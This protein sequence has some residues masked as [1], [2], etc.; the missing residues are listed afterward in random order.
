[1]TAINPAIPIASCVLVSI[2]TNDPD[3][4]RFLGRSTAQRQVEFAAACGCREVILLGGGG[5]AS[6]IATRHL[7]E[8]LGLAVREVS[9]PH[10]LARAGLAGERMLVLQADL[11]PDPAALPAGT[12]MAS[13]CIITLTAGPGVEAGYERIDLAR[14]WAGLLVLPGALL[15]RLLDLPEDAEPASALLRIG[16]QAGLPD[17]P[18]ALPHLSDGSWCLARTPEDG[19]LAEEKWLARYIAVTS[20]DPVSRQLAHGVLRRAA[21]RLLDRSWMLPL[22][23][24]LALAVP[25]AG[26]A[27]CYWGRAAAGF[28]AIALAA[29]LLEA[30]LGLSH[31]QRARAGHFGRADSKLGHLRK[32]LDLAILAAGVLAVSGTW[33]ERGFAPLVLLAALYSMPPQGPAWF[34]RWRDRGLAAALVAVGA[35]AMTAQA[36]LMLAALAVLALNLVQMHRRVG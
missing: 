28:I 1:M 14:A 17:R 36:G 32:A 8:G 34:T 10:A 24:G 20:G 29:P 18:L 22:A 21:G 3:R 15:P 31:L 35:L 4:A 33:L 13:G 6:A 16:L 11:L 9:G 27:L 26:V 19:R 30:A 25:V 5:S 12:E 7:A 2:T 23:Y